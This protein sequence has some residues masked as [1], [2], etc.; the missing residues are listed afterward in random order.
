MGLRPL[1]L[2][3]EN[4]KVIG[5]T[6]YLPHQMPEYELKRCDKNATKNLPQIKKDN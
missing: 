5:W 4:G 6:L 1:H 3:I 2:V